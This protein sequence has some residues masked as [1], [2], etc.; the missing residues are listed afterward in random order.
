MPDYSISGLYVTRILDQA[1][2]LRGL[3]RTIRTD[4]GSEFIGIALEQW[5]YRN[6]VEL[7]L[8]EA[9]KPVQ[10]AYVEN[11]NGKFRDECLNE[12]GFA[13]L[14]HAEAEIGACRCDLQ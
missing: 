6:G 11:Y 2:L 9:G 3:P 5:A 10:N 12:H 7:R 8:I 4:Q 14:A 1:A 13:N